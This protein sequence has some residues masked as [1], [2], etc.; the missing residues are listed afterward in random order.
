MVAFVFR[1]FLHLFKADILR[2]NLIYN[3]CIFTYKILLKN[4]QLL[5][6]AKIFCKIVIFYGCIYFSKFLHRFKTCTLR[7]NLTYNTCTFTQ[8]N[9]SK[10]RHQ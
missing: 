1:K 5:K 10:T 8:N 2:F 4:Y 7:F 6:L 9:T 3:T